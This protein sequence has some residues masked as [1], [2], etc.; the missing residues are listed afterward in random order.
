[1]FVGI[2]ALRGIDD[3]V[4]VI[5]FRPPILL[6]LLFSLSPSH[7]QCNPLLAKDWVPQIVAKV[8]ATEMEQALSLY[9]QG[10][11]NI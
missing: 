4:Q 2:F 11:R 9:V 10:A 6:F 7:P 5:P 8:A 1:M 3:K